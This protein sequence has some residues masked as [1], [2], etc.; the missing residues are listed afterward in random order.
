M[1]TPPSGKRSVPAD[2]DLTELPT[3]PKV[4]R[5][6]CFEEGFPVEVRSTGLGLAY[7]SAQLVFAAFAPNVENALWAAT[8]WTAAPAIWNY[9]GALCTAGA[10]LYIFA[11]GRREYS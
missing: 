10:L 5:A 4:P 9:V 3:P 2:D 6:A 11:N 1:A 8:G 7:N